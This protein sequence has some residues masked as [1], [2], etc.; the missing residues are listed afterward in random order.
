VLICMLTAPL[1]ME[2]FRGCDGM[3]HAMH[4]GPCPQ[5]CM[6]E[7]PMQPTECI[8]LFGGSGNYIANVHTLPEGNT[9]Q[10]CQ[11]ARPFRRTQQQ[12]HLQSLHPEKHQQDSGQHVV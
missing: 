2:G 11:G 3:V 6:V 12:A 9:M 10:S 4:R 5:T 7:P 8:R 1:H